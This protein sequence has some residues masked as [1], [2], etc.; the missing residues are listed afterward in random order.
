[1]GCGLSAYVTLALSAVRRVL[2]GPV[3]GLGQSALPG[4]RAGALPISPFHVT[5]TAGCFRVCLSHAA[6]RKPFVS[7]SST[8]ANMPKGR[9]YKC[10][11][12][13]RT[14]AKPTGKRC[15]WV[16]ME[17]LEE[18]D[19]LLEPVEIESSANELAEALRG[20]TS[21][22]ENMGKRMAELEGAKGRNT[23]SRVSEQGERSEAAAPHTARADLASLQC[24]SF[25]AIMRLAGRSIEGWQR[26]I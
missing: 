13:T 15:P 2:Q 17:Q 12:C 24:K 8:T 5:R 11:A 3:L 21:Q 6:L 14:H 25:G 1:M 18:P 10:T 26:W 23:G 20:L 4:T 9:T 16:T 19:E 22:V 7:R